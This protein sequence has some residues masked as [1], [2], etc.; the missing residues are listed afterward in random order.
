M[1]VM[2]NVKGWNEKNEWEGWGQTFELVGPI[3]GVG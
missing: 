2:C 1:C 3:S